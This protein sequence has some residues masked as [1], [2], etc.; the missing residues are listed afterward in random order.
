MPYQSKI[1]HKLSTIITK[2]YKIECA[3]GIEVEFY[4]IP[5]NRYK[6][7]TI[8][9]LAEKLKQCGVSV[10][11]ED[12]EDQY[13]IRI[14]HTTDLNRLCEKIEMCNKVLENCNQHIIITSAKPFLKKNASSAQYNISLH[15]DSKNIFSQSSITKNDHLT[16]YVNSILEMLNDALYFLLSQDNEEYA[17]FGSSI[18]TP[19]TVSW[20][21]NNRTAAIRIPSSYHENRRI[22]FRVP[23]PK[24]S[25]D[26]VVLFLLISLLHKIAVSQK[27]HYSPIYGNAHDTALYGGEPLH[28]SHKAAA[29]NFR[30]PE[31]II[32]ISNAFER[33]DYE[34]QNILSEIHALLLQHK[35]P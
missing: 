21:I 10:V 23:S 30:L 26:N 34:M 11:K 29:A 35:I 9:E 33:S 1:I 27:K 17:R 12:D 19:L 22:E 24:S 20:G 7:S 8:V 6:H 14:P 3:I 31:R 25:H 5:K 16:S 2:R 13:E 4:A 18:H 15:I 32:L 28:S